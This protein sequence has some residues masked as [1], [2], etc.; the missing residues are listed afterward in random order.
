[1][2]RLTGVLVPVAWC[3]EAAESP[4]AGA[5]G[6]GGGRTPPPPPPID[7]T[8]EAEGLQERE[9]EKEMGDRFAKFWC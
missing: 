7:V 9:D 6:G 3:I 2:E 4:G 5:R 1:M 8:T